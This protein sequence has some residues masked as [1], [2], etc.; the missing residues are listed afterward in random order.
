MS[1]RRLTLVPALVGLMAVLS[2]AGRAALAGDG[3]LGQSTGA[4]HLARGAQSVVPNIVFMTLTKMEGKLDRIIDQDLTGDALKREVGEV[5]GL[6][7]GPLVKQGFAGETVFGLPFRRV[8]RNLENIELLLERAIRNVRSGVDVAQQQAK[9]H[10][11]VA[12]AATERLKELLAGGEGVPNR[13]FR[14]LNRMNYRLRLIIVD[15]NIT[16]DGL[17]LEIREVLALKL[18][19]RP[20]FD[21]ETVFGLSFFPVYQELENIDLFLEEA[22]F[23]DKTDERIPKREGLRHAKAATRR[24]ERRLR[25]APSLSISPIDANFDEADR[26]TYYTVPTVTNPSGGAIAFRWT[27]SLQAVDPNAGVDNGCVNTRGG[28]F[29]GTGSFFMWAH[30]NT[31]DPVHD[32]GC[33]HSL[34]GQYGHQGLI[35]VRVSNSRGQSCTATYKGTESSALAPADAASNPSCTGSNP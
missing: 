5:E 10:L 21:T 3:G 4:A 1:R 16:G 35:T 15:R 23:Y 25:E 13:L 31:G 20:D 29:S 19:L 11:V 33:D 34:E 22:V 27:L 2:L 30:G 12:R 7:H 18:E 24:L 26:A 28:G 9:K 8:Y 32:D 17:K 6:K 14:T